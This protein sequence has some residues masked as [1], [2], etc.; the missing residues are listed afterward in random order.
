MLLIVLIVVTVTLKGACNIEHSMKKK[1][2]REK[3]ENSK[4]I[5][6]KPIQNFQKKKKKCLNQTENETKLIDHDPSFDLQMLAAEQVPRVQELDDYTGVCDSRKPGRR[7]GF[8]SS[9]M[10]EHGRPPGVP[11]DIPHPGLPGVA[12]LSRAQV[13]RRTMRRTAFLL[14]PYPRNVGSWPR[15]TDVGTASLR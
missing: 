6:K 5:E 15:S 12:L 13:K 3:K 1:K 9:T 10:G 14:P 4:E 2:K 8:R 7:Q 11:S